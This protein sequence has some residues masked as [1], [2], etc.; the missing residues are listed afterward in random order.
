MPVPMAFE[1]ENVE[2]DLSQYE[3]GDV[4]FILSPFSL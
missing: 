4:E 2:P 1:L 3:P